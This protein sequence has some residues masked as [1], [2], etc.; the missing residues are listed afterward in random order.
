MVRALGFNV[1]DDRWADLWPWP[2][3]TYVTRRG[4]QRDRERR[5]IGEVS[6]ETGRADLLPRPLYRL[7]YIGGHAPGPRLFETS[8]DPG[9][10]SGV[11]MIWRE[12][13]GPTLSRR[14]PACRGRT[15]FSTRSPLPGRPAHA[16]DSPLDDDRRIRRLRLAGPHARRRRRRRACLGTV[17]SVD[18]DA[19]KVVVTEKD[20]D[21]DI[22]VTDQGRHRVGEPQGQD[23][24]RSTSS[25][26]SKRVKKGTKMD[27]LQGGQGLEE[28]GR[29]DQSDDW[30]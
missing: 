22:D 14:V 8:R 13:R 19:K 20:T 6:A 24:S 17:K 15:A 5:K 2:T 11:R 23:R 3:W 27:R 25:P 4:L 21:K 30:Q 26:S 1:A 16:S 10:R 18:V 28:E 12:A 7:H 29:H 9:R